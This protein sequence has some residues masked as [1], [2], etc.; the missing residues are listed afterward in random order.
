MLGKEE[1][2]CPECESELIIKV[3]GKDKYIK[4]SGCNF[5]DEEYYEPER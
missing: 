1:K 5:H 4:C 2:Y 3:F